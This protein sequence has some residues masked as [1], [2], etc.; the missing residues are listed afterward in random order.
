MA[1][2]FPKQRELKTKYFGC[3]CWCNKRN[4]Y[5]SSNTIIRQGWSGIVGTSY[6]LGVFNSS[7]CFLGH[8][9]CCA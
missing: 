1:Q 2:K 9:C 6:F 7:S 8:Y 4:A 5:N 3:T